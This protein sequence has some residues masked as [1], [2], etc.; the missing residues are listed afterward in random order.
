[1]FFITFIIFEESGLYVLNMLVGVSGQ[2]GEISSYI[3]KNSSMY[4]IQIIHLESW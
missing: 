1:M 3:H 4:Q 2:L